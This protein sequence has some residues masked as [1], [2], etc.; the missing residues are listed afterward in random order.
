MRIPP[1]PIEIRTVEYDKEI[2]VFWVCEEL[3]TPEY[4][5]RYEVESDPPTFTMVVARSPARFRRLTNG[6]KYKFQVNAVHQVGKATSEWSK[7][8]IPDDEIPKEQYLRN[9]KRIVCE[10]GTAEQKKK[11]EQERQQK[12]K[13]MEEQRQRV[14]QNKRRMSFLAKERT[15]NMNNKFGGRGGGRNMTTASAMIG[16]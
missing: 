8:A 4:S 9:K 6:N 11:E 14:M 1:K 12:K 10:K 7:H 5:G 13:K 2:T 3:K 16:G 15:N